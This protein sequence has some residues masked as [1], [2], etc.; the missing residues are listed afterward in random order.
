MLYLGKEAADSVM[1][2]DNISQFTHIIGGLVGGS[3]GY[4]LN[5]RR[6]SDV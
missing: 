4:I 6:L 3:M 1:V 5:T 2:N